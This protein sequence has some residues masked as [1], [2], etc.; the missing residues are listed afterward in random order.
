MTRASL[1]AGGGA[2]VPAAAGVAAARDVALARGRTGAG[3]AY[4]GVPGTLSGGGC[5]GPDVNAG[6][7]VCGCAGPGVRI[8]G[9][10]KDGVA[11]GAGVAEVGPTM[12]MLMVGSLRRPSIG[13]SA[14]LQHRHT[15]IR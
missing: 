13:P 6:S 15:T 12:S 7:G 5:R 8:I 10:L 11:S 1:C 14:P 2:G 9:V 3:V 4:C